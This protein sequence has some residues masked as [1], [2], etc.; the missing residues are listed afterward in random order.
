MIIQHHIPQLDETLAP[1]RPRIGAD[2]DAYRNH[3]YRM[4]NFCFALAEPDATGQHKIA[5]AACFH[6]L[7]LWTHDTLDY[8]RPSAA[9]AREWL[10]AQGHA[11]WAEEID[12]MI[13]LHHRFRPWRV[14]GGELVEAFRK[15][16]LVDV[17]LGMIRFG[18]P[19]RFVADVRA[20]FPNAGFHKRLVQLTLRQ[21][22]RN[23]LRPLPM[24][25]W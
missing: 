13:D 19:R 16:D 9:L 10:Q 21:L 24:M 4:V 15:A 14:P 5:V 23:P 18:L 22:R 6:D 7:G 11:D 17:S 20:A 1:W 25:K 12:A 3:L 8:L 2:Y